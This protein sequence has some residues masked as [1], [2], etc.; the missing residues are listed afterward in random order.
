M[1]CIQV[2]EVFLRGSSIKKL[3]CYKLVST[4]AVTVIHVGIHNVF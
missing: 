4:F 3:K 2:K 1:M